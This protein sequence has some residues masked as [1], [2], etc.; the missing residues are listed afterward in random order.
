[1]IHERKPLPF[2]AE[3]SSYFQISDMTNMAAQTMR[4]KIMPG[5]RQ[6]T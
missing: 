2:K 1:M 6:E 4:K 3:D 5:F